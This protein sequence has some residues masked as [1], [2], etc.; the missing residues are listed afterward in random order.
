MAGQNILRSRH[1]TVFLFRRRVPLDSQCVVD[2][3]AIHTALR[4]EFASEA[5]RRALA[6]PVATACRTAD[7]W[8]V[9]QSMWPGV[10]RFRE[11]FDGLRSRQLKACVLQL[12]CPAPSA[13]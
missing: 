13:G 2:G 8:A 11:R 12:P 1:G 4:T 3:I 6:L 5:R 7:D 10:A 9:E